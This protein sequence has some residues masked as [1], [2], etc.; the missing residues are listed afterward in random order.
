MG[1]RDRQGADGGCTRITGVE[2]WGRRS[3]SP[4]AIR[5]TGVLLQSERGRLAASGLLTQ[6][7]VEL[8]AQE[9]SLSAGHSVK[10]KPS[11]TTVT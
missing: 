9:F 10:R 11:Q 4:L 5:L 2:S 3:R 7:W 8:Q 1:C 6:S